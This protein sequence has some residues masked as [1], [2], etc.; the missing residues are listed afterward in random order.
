MM[1]ASTNRLHPRS[2]CPRPD[3]AQDPN[4]E[5]QD[6]EEGVGEEDAGEFAEEILRGLAHPRPLPM[7]PSALFGYIAAACTQWLG[8][9][10][11]MHH[12]VVLYLMCTTS[13]FV[14]QHYSLLL[15]LPSRLPPSPSNV[16]AP[17][18]PGARVAGGA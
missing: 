12:N 7:Q 5:E 14:L 1:A 11:F 17:L 16:P 4:G 13:T 9:M 6:E 2:P 8:S 18:R 10:S 3:A 15:S